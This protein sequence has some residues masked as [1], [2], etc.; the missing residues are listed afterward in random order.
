MII[1]HILSHASLIS[2]VVAI[3]I[4]AKYGLYK[5][6]PFQIDFLQH[7]CNYTIN[8]RENHSLAILELAFLCA[9]AVL[10]LVVMIMTGWS[11]T[12][13]RHRPCCS[14]TCCGSSVIDDNKCC[15]DDRQCC[16]CIRGRNIP[17]AHEEMQ[18]FNVKY[19]ENERIT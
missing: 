13:L 8:F 17:A 11:L 4:C 19:T 18:T 10:S 2:G 5:C 1:N 6:Q 16:T 7:S 14:S 12:I 9:A 3:V 15:D